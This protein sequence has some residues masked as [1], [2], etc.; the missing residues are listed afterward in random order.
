MLKPPRRIADI[1]IVVLLLIPLMWLHR[2]WKVHQVAALIETWLKQQHGFAFRVVNC[3]I[4]IPLATST[5]ECQGELNSSTQVSI[6][7]QRDANGGYHWEIPTSKQVLNLSELE[8]QFQDEIFKQTKTRPVIHCGGQYRL[9]EVG[10]R[11]ICQMMNQHQE[12]IIL[13]QVDDQNDVTW[14]IVEAQPVSRSE[15]VLKSHSVTSLSPTS[16]DAFL[17][18]PAATQ[19]F[20]D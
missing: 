19:G 2:Q 12:N 3:P 18:L 14:Q 16:A 5:F 10:D 20:H 1:S 11:F 15:T 7:V 4:L 6:I 8:H 17:N 13:V 9:N